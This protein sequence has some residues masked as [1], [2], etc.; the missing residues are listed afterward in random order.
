MNSCLPTDR[1]LVQVSGDEAEA[2]LNRLVT[3]NIAGMAQGEARYAALLSPQ[4]KLAV[5]FLVYRRADGFLLD[6]PA[7]E[8]AALAKKLTL[9]KRGGR[10]LGRHA[11]GNAGAGVPRPPA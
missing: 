9:F 3:R 5:D 2:F 11:R 4:G 1:A 7:S 10:D 8:A 6:A